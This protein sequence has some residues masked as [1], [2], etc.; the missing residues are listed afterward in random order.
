MAK[1]TVSGKPNPQA[2]CFLLDSVYRYLMEKELAKAER[3]SAGDGPA[4]SALEVTGTG[5]VENWTNTEYSEKENLCVFD[6]NQV[7]ARAG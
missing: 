6:E 1:Y 5:G 4:L 2:V 7:P 3:E